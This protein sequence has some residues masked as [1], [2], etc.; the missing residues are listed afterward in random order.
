MMRFLAVAVALVCASVPVYAQTS[1]DMQGLVV[2]GG[3]FALMVV[4]FGFH[5][6]VD[7]LKPELPQWA[8][9]MIAPGVMT[10][11]MWLNEWANALQVDTTM[12]YAPLAGLIVDWVHDQIVWWQSE[13]SV[14]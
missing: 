4:A 12:W 1:V 6:L 13:G 11:L 2:S 8:W 14:A 3:M 9:L 5:W 7:K 10:G